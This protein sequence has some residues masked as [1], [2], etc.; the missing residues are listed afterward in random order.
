MIKREVF[1]A[2]ESVPILSSYGSVSEIIKAKAA[3]AEL[4]AARMTAVL[5]SMQSPFCEL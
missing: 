5:L 1:T 4:W 2:K 3:S